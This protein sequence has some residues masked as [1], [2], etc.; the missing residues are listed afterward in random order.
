MNVVHLYSK[1]KSKRSLST[2]PDIQQRLSEYSHPVSNAYIS[3]VR[4]LKS[5][6]GH[7]YDNIFIDDDSYLEK[8]RYLDQFVETLG[9][10]ILIVPPLNS[11]TNLKDM[12]RSMGYTLINAGPYMGCAKTGK[13]RFAVNLMKL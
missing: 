2:R 8:F 7:S 1:I 12:A 11:K 6:N 3:D 13:I 4:Y 5:D 9:T 10:V